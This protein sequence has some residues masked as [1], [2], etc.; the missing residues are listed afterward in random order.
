MPGRR[1]EGIGN[2]RQTPRYRKLRNVGSKPLRL[3]HQR[4]GEAIRV[5][6]R[7]IPTTS[8]GRKRTHD[9]TEYDV[10]SE[11]SC[12]YGR[13]GIGEV[14]EREH[15]VDVAT[16]KEV[17]E[18]PHTSRRAPPRT[19]SNRV[20]NG[21]VAMCKQTCGCRRR[22]E[23]RERAGVAFRFKG[24]QQNGQPPLY[25][26]DPVRSEEQQDARVRFRGGICQPGTHARDSRHTH[27]ASD[28]RRRHEPR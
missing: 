4:V 21:D 11:S 14:A 2:H 12:R 19:G 22:R 28:S 8:A 13:E 24:L 25:A 23:R 26:A 20:K 6:D 27:Q 10:P 16:A 15:N 3:Q 18:S 1:R 7:S 5:H 17:T 9:F